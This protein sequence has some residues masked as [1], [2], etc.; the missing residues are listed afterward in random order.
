MPEW[1]KGFDSSS[2]SASCTGSNPVGCTFW[3]P[4]LNC[5]GPGRRGGTHRGRARRP[6]H[7]PLRR[8]QKWGEQVRR[9]T[10]VREEPLARPGL[11]SPGQSFSMVA[12]CAHLR[13]IPMARATA[14]AVGPTHDLGLG[15]SAASVDLAD[16]TCGT[17]AILHLNECSHSRQPVLLRQVCC[18]SQIKTARSVATSGGFRTVVMREPRAQC[19]SVTVYCSCRDHAHFFRL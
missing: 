3:A 16:I 17:H 1:S 11:T 12:G 7:L 14:A 2:N 8:F 10:V 4:P 5:I 6:V 15:S 9:A 18:G 19:V 13:D